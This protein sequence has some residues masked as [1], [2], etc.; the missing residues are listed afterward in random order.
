VPHGFC[1]GLRGPAA[2]LEGERFT[3]EVV[4][5]IMW[6]G[7]KAIRYKV[8]MNL[9]GQIVKLDETILAAEVGHGGYPR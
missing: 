4:A 2:C 9:S 1:E 7:G 8:Q 5:W 6:E 3:L